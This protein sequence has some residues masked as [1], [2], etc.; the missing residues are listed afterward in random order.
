MKTTNQTTCS[1]YK[2]LF[3]S[4]IL[5]FSINRVSA[6]NDWQLKTDKEGIKVYTSL[7]PDSKIKA[8]KV[9]AE[10]N[11]TPAQMVSLLMDV[12][13]STEW[14]YHLKSAVLIKQ[15]SPSELYY[16]SEVSLPWPAA[17]RDFVAHLTVTQN[18]DTK[19]ITV[20]G[21]AV[22]GL[23]PLK[24]GIVRISDS[25]GKWVITPS[26]D[27]RIKVEY[28]IH[29]DPGGSLPSWLVNMFATEGPL[30]IF[31]NIRSQ[32]QKPVY[33]NNVLAVAAN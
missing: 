31:K 16:Y 22:S 32:L 25:K 13:T 8:I 28:S 21:P 10:F 19:V 33:K 14:V 20:E 24:Q 3:L 29:V 9:D 27:N 6:Q 11:A 26:G 23:V 5:V 12:K 18:P 7:V 1:I 2:L 15:I 30:K 4:L 17:D